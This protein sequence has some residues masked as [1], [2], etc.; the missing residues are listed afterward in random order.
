MKFKNVAVVSLAATVSAVALGTVG[1]QA[2]TLIGSSQ[3]RD[4]AVRSADVRDGTLQA[5]DMSATARQSLRGHKGD[6]GAIGP[7][8]PQGL[9]GD[10]GD[11][12]MLGAFYATAYYNAGDTNAGAIATV[13]CDTD[14]TD[15]TAIAGGAQ[16]LGLDASA[17]TRNTPVSSSFPGRMDWSTNSPKANRLDGWIVQFGGNAGETS[18]KSPEKVKVWALCLPGTDIPVKQTYSQN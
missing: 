15:Y 1:A 11:K 3:I 14:S 8:G 12:G 13:A 2:A 6:T 7:L 9:K 17:N 5:K 18:D 10:K 16:V 4:N